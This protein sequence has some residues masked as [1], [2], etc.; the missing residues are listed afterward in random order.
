MSEDSAFTS[1]ESVNQPSAEIAYSYCSVPKVTER[2]FATDVDPDRQ[3]LIL[4][5]DDMWLNGTVLHYYFFDNPPQWRGTDIQKDVVRKAFQTWK[6]V[7]I[8]LDFKEVNSNTEAE[9]R[10]GF[11]QGDGSWSYLGRDILRRGITE[12]TMN[13]GWDISSTPREHDTAIHEIG[14]TLG[15]PHEHQN[16]LAGIVWDEEKVYATLAGSP[17]N[18][19]RDTT[20]FNIIRKLGTNEVK[21]S[22]WDPKSVMHYPFTS[23]LVRTPPYDKLGINPPGGLSEEDRAVVQKFYPTLPTQEIEL[24]PFRSFTLDVQGD[25]QQNFLIKPDATRVYNFATFGASDA[26]LGLFE[27]IDG[28]P[29]FTDAD[30]DSGE[31]RNANLQVKLFAGREYILRVR[32]Y[33][34]RDEQVAVMTW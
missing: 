1:E 8:G 26:V 28:D 25:R 33:H 13:F 19:D 17:N 21:G 5:F 14:H 32:V 7:G 15:F 22:A 24:K 29:R 10:I 23:G 20:F 18:W 31:E 6:D 34:T 27:K 4:L 16:P 2:V 11:L 30:D 3:Q 9:I 12:R